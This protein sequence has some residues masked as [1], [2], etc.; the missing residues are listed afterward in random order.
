[1]PTLSSLCTTGSF[2]KA[3]RY[4]LLFLFILILLIIAIVTY[5]WMMKWFL[6]MF[7]ASLL[8]LLWL[9]SPPPLC[10]QTEEIEIRP[11]ELKNNKSSLWISGVYFWSP[12]FGFFSWTNNSWI[13]TPLCLH[14]ISECRKQRQDQAERACSRLPRQRRAVLHPADASTRPPPSRRDVRLLRAVQD[15]PWVCRAAIASG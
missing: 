14:A 10:L 6:K 2:I 11:R 3:L 9:K 13:V 5:R 8:L 12:H 7:P 4:S 1:M 15:S